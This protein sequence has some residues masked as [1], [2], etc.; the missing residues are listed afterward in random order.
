MDHCHVVAKLHGWCVMN[1]KLCVL[2][3]T[4]SAVATGTPAIAGEIY[5]FVDDDGNVH[6]VLTPDLSD[7]AEIEKYKAF[8]DELADLVVDKYDGSLKAEHG[9]G[10]NMAPFVRRE[11]GEQIYGAMQEVKAIFDPDHMLNPGVIINDD[12]R[13]YRF[14]AI[15]RHCSTRSCCPNSSWP[16][17]SYV[18]CP[19][20][21]I[22]HLAV[23]LA[24][25]Y[26]PRQTQTDCGGRQDKCV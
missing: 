17:F 8:M 3:L 5:K 15:V 10:R 6:F 12:Q 13:C 4:A 2:I 19:Q 22:E 25:L 18:N 16:S 23:R 9:T 7:E 14:W 20:K 11:W 24:L 26:N 21:S 1:R